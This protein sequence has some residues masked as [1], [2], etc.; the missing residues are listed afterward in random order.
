[1]TTKAKPFLYMVK[2]KRFLFMVFAE[3]QHPLLPCKPRTPPSVTQS[4][5]SS[6]KQSTK[7][8][9]F[10]AQSLVTYIHK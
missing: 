1:M 5:K 6:G 10:G 2:A 9:K 4:E 3:T 7:A 8:F